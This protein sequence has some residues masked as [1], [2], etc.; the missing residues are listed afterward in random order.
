MEQCSKT[1]ISFPKQSERSFNT[2]INSPFSCFSCSPATLKLIGIF[3]T[4]ESTHNIF[5]N[6]KTFNLTSVVLC[7]CV[8][9]IIEHFIFFA[10]R[11]ID[12]KLLPAFHQLSA[13]VLNVHRFSWQVLIKEALD[14]F[15]GNNILWRWSHSLL[16]DLLTNFF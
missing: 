4:E 2:I 12:T 11:I 15:S 13:F 3:W 1:I 6:T 5:F 7:L 16:K 14:Q 9:V 10:S 8:H